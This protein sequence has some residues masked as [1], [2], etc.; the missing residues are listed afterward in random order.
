[1]EN[2]FRRW[3]RENGFGHTVKL[4]VVRLW[5]EEHPSG[6]RRRP[7]WNVQANDESTGQTLAMCGH[8]HPCPGSARRCL[9]NSDMWRVYYRSRV[10]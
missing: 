1:M 9:K 8:N 5:E 3:L 7:K 10:G 6:R 4:S 2:W